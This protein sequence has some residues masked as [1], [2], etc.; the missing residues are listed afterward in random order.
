MY[1]WVDECISGWVDVWLGVWM[2]GWVGGCMDG[3]VDV[4]LDGWMYGL[5]DVWIELLKLGIKYNL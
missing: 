3:W 2:Y 5:V 4:S 1:G